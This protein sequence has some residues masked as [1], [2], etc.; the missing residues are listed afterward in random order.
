ME[1]VKDISEY[2]VEKSQPSHDSSREDENVIILQGGGSLGAFFCGVFKVFAKNNLK[3]DLIGGTSI[4][5]IN[6]AIIAGSKNNNPAKDLED[7]WMELSD[8]NLNIIPNKVFFG[9]NELK[10]SN[11]P[12][13]NNFISYEFPEMIEISSAAINASLF[14]VPKMFTP[15][16]NTLQPFPYL[17]KDISNTFFGNYFFSN[18]TYFYDHSPLEQTLEKYIDYN[19]LSPKSKNHQN[20]IRL[21]V[22][23]VNVLTGEPVIFDSAKMKIESKHLLA[24]CGYPIYGFPWVEVEKGVYVWDGSLLSNTPLREIME[25]SP[26]NDKH[27]FIVENY[28]REITCLPS[29]F[30]EVQDRAK[31]IMFS[32]KTLHDI[33]TS[34]LITSQIQLIEKLYREWETNQN[35]HTSNYTDTEIKLIKEEY[36]KLINNYGAEIHCVTKISRNR[37]ESP[38]VMKNADFSQKTIHELINQGEKKGDQYLQYFRDK[39]I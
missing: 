8:S 33:Q 31:D 15:R 16:W 9:L 25:S 1:K 11:I 38:H 13:L 34:R 18:W 30:T 20:F 27:I 28:P 39:H 21:V 4:G 14:G 6:G 22:T 29:N 35:N 7:F 17:G 19:K 37:M 10:K 2:V 5:A 3:I 36:N 32:D 23:G 24:S 26:R 12:N